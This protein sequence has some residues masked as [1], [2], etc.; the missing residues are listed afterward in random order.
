MEEGVSAVPSGDRGGG[1]EGRSQEG[2]E[3][4]R[5]KA[6]RAVVP[7][8]WW[9]EAARA[10]MLAAP[11]PR[12]MLCDQCAERG[13]VTVGGV[14]TALGALEVQVA[15]K[16]VLLV[17]RCSPGGRAEWTVRMAMPHAG[18][19]ALLL[20]GVLNAG[21]LAASAAGGEEGGRHDGV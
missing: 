19:L 10:R 9:V 5:C 17:E 1:C 11:S 18:V 14:P 20:D 6:C 13:A 4:F 12:D 15:G 16:H 8:R 21:R 3:W 2:Q 7:V